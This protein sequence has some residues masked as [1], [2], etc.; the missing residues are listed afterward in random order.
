[1]IVAVSGI[2]Y[3]KQRWLAI[4]VTIASV[5]LIFWYALDCASARPPC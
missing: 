3:D 4:L 5:L 2:V 1:L